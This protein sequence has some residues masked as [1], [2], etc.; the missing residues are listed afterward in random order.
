MRTT[1]A[2]TKL[3]IY[4][5]RGNTS[6]H[7]G[8]QVGALCQS[9]HSSLLRQDFLCGIGHTA[10]GRL[11]PFLHAAA[12]RRLPCWAAQ[13]QAASDEAALS[14]PPLALDRTVPALPPA[15]VLRLAC[16]PRQAAVHS[17]RQMRVGAL[18]L[19][20]SCPAVKQSRK[21]LKGPHPSPFPFSCACPM[22][23][24]PAAPRFRRRVIMN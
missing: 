24:V 4:N 2:H 17:S 6:G 13:L 16:R 15:S 11:P 20:C 10:A 18:P 19:A 9:A 5:S 21:K 12:G 3:S 8:N 23:V 7:L 22:S 1:N 14:G